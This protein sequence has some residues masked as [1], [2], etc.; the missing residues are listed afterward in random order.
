MVV[1]RTIL[2]FPTLPSPVNALL[3]V[4]VAGLPP[5]FLYRRLRVYLQRPRISFE[6]P[7]WHDRQMQNSGRD[8]ASRTTGTLAVFF[9]P[10]TPRAGRPSGCLAVR[11]LPPCG[12]RTPSWRASLSVFVP[13]RSF[14]ILSSDSDLSVGGFRVTGDSRYAHS[15]RV[16]KGW[17]PQLS[18]KGKPLPHQKMTSS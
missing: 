9:H 10:S 11:V 8:D 12:F 5:A 1:C 15:F 16:S 6:S 13:L 17:Q 18:T 4:L 7:L 14:P 3:S 2:A